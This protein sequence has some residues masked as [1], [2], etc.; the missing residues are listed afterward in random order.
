MVAGRRARRGR[1][2]VD[3]SSPSSDLA[4]VEEGSAGARPGDAD[5]ASGRRTCGSGRCG[6]GRANHA[7]R[8]PRPE[9]HHQRR[10]SCGSRCGV[11]DA[12]GRR[13]NVGAEAPP[14]RAIPDGFPGLLGSATRA[15]GVGLID[16]KP[17]FD[18]CCGRGF[19]P[20]RCR[21][22]EYSDSGAGRS[23][24]YDV[25]RAFSH[26][27][28]FRSGGCAWC[29]SAFA[30]ST[31]SRRITAG[32]SVITARDRRRNHAARADRSERRPR[33]AIGSANNVCRLR[34]RR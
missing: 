6:A 19:S 16:A 9:H 30:G 14:A 20:D 31:D 22:R 33:G 3:A 23:A 25:N 10:A 13:E 7:Y 11:C 1:V 4:A 18:A 15:G 8:A 24:D 29:G 26:E 32:G 2:F 17:A 21:R 12:R 27:R 5:P 28:R 34:H